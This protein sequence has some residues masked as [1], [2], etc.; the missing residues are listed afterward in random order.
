M[1]KWEDT[2]K[3]GPAPHHQT[4]SSTDETARDQPISARDQQELNQMLAAL[5]DRD[6]EKVSDEDFR[7]QMETVFVPKDSPHLGIVPQ[8]NPFLHAGLVTD[9]CKY[10]KF[11]C[12]FMHVIL[13]S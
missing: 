12:P 3:M 2:R 13:H 10:L 4:V 6:E 9:G 7:M 1:T 11:S 8:L 5:F